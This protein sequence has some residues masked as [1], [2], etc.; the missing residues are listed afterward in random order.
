MNLEKKAKN[1]IFKSGKDTYITKIELVPTKGTNIYNKEGIFYV[2]KITC[3]QYKKNKLIKTMDKVIFPEKTDRNDYNE[4]HKGINILNKAGTNYQYGT[5]KQCNF[6]K[7]Y[8]YNTNKDII[9]N[10]KDCINILKNNNLYIDNEIEF[11]KKLLIA[12]LPDNFIEIFK[13]I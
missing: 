9:K 10:A 6:L 2:L 11:G 8:G 3:H 4:I 13:S 5:F 12:T 7:R 1:Y